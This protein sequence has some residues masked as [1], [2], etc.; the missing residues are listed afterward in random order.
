LTSQK[1]LH[2]INLLLELDNPSKEAWIL[3]RK[4]ERPL[5]I[6]RALLAAA[7]PAA[8]AVILL[9]QAAA[10]IFA[11][12]ASVALAFA[13]V[14]ATRRGVRFILGLAVI[15]TV[16]LAVFFRV[17]ALIAAAAALLAP[18][19]A[20]ANPVPPSQN[21]TVIKLKIFVHHLM[22]VRERHTL[23]VAAC[24]RFAALSHHQAARKHFERWQNL[25][26]SLCE[27]G[28][29]YKVRAWE[30]QRKIHRTNRKHC[31]QHVELHDGIFPLR[32]LH[33]DLAL[34][35][36]HDFNVI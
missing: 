1:I 9:G 17:S 16:V 6:A 27:G 5:I 15:L 36:F 35:F 21:P 18:P 7:L 28:G 30:Q 20:P 12:A 24:L 34:V 13:T 26:E 33:V 32:R 19:P 3:T 29:I 11:V 22:R 31:R 8:P 25:G 10:T 23:V 14:R 4:S 2:Q